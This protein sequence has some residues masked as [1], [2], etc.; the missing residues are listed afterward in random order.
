MARS[1]H[2]MIEEFGIAAVF[3]MIMGGDMKFF[4]GGIIRHP[5]NYRV[6][7]DPIFDPGGVDPPLDII[8]QNSAR[9]VR[10]NGS[11]K[12]RI[13]TVIRKFKAFFGP[14]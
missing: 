6:K 9:R 10:G 5:T 3:F 11:T 8:K 4:A 13:K 7:A 2:H 1:H 12:M 14:I